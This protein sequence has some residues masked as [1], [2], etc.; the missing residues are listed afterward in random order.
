MRN[1]SLATVGGICALV[2]VA[3][4]VGGIV[5]SIVGGVQVLIPETG[6]EGLA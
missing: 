6:T 5:L 2:T 4:F 3:G 1:L